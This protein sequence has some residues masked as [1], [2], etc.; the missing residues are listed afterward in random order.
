MEFLKPGILSEGCQRFSRLPVGDRGHFTTVIT[1]QQ[2]RI[3][4]PRLLSYHLG[5]NL[6]D[7][8]ECG[9]LLP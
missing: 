1:F 5:V 3:H 2:L 9:L 4:K 6:M 7:T 8:V